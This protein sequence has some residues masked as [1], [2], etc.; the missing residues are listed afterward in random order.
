LTPGDYPFDSSWGYQTTGYFG[1]TSRYGSPDDFRYFVDKAHQAQLGVILD[2]VPAHFPKGG[3]ALSFFDG[4]HLY[5]HA[6]S[7]KGEHQDWE[8]LIYNYGRNEVRAFLLS[9]AL[10]TPA[11]AAMASVRAPSNPS[12]P[13]VRSAASNMVTRVAALL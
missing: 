1:P 13:K 2:W 3:S 11:A 9:S 10:L 7:R 4:T 8:T 12:S 6:D 5:E